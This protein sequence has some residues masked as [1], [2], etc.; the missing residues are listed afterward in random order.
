[1]EKIRARSA[2]SGIFEVVALAVNPT[3]AAHFVPF[4]ACF[5]REAMALNRHQFLVG[6]D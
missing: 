2:L 3:V 4:A 5:I 1:M 6:N